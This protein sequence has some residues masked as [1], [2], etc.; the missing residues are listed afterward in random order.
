VVNFKPIK[1]NVLIEL[2][3]PKEKEGEIILADVTKSVQN[4]Q[5][6]TVIAVGPGK[7]GKDGNRLPMSVEAGQVILIGDVQNCTPVKSGDKHRRW[8]MF[9]EESLAGICDGFDADTDV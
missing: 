7:R 2:F 9:K 1:D 5:Y 8:L 4:L 3:P 6:A